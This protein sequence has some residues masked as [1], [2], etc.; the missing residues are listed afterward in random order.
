MSLSIACRWPEIGLND[1]KAISK[2][3]Q[4]LYP[5]PAVE[6]IAGP[7][8]AFDVESKKY[9]TYKYFARWGLFAR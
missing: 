6:T 1:N 3:A 5:H 7:S 9:A 4:Q 2:S 8:Q